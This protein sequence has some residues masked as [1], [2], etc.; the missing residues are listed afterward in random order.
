M[1]TADRFITLVQLV[2]EVTPFFA[3]VTVFLVGLLLCASG[4]QL[5]R[6]FTR[7]D[8]RGFVF[9][10]LAAVPFFFLWFGARMMH[11]TE[12]TPAPLW[13]SCT[14]LATFVTML[15]VGL[16]LLRHLSAWRGVF[17]TVFALEIWLA[18]ASAFVAEISVSGDYYRW[19]QS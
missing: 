10:G 7:P 18:I 9:V 19:L 2:P 1:N 8:W 13:P 14:I 5:W 12:R 16:S 15:A 3:V 6:S 4:R 17:V 11:L